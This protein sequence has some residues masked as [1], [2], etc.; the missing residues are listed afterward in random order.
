MKLTLL[1]TVFA[2]VSGVVFAADAVQPA[3]TA[4]PQPKENA[5]MPATANPT[6]LLSTSMGDITIELYPDKAPVSVANFLAYVDD[7]TYDGTIFHRVIPGFMLQGGGFTPDMTQK[8]TRAPIKNE[9]DNGLLNARGTLSMARTMVVDSATCQ[10]FVNTV[11]NKFL[12]FK[13]K[14]QQGYGYAVF[15]KV[16]AGMDVVDQI[17]KVPTGNQGG[18]QNVPVTPVTILKATRTT[19]AAK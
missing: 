14:T 11:D 15:A 13:S 16:I 1:A 5:A 3:E 18:H 9:A 4:T 17:A 2:M 19:P 12:D 6:V 10:F 7:K 8:P